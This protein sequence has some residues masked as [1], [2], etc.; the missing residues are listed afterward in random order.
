MSRGEDLGFMK[1][2]GGLDS[3]VLL[4][5]GDVKIEFPLAE[6]VCHYITQPLV[7]LYGGCM[8]VL[9]VSWCLNVQDDRKLSKEF[10]ALGA[11]LKELEAAAQQLSRLSGA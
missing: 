3:S 5:L 9:K 7:E 10:T 8:V 1:G 11:E 4:S 2:G 6:P